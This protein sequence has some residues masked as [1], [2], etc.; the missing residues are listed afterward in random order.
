MP[1][2]PS[3]WWHKTRH[4]ERRPFLL[5]RTRLKEAVRAFFLAQD[6]MEVDTCPLQISPGNEV[7]LHPFQTELVDA[8]GSRYP[9]YLPTSPEFACKKLLAAGESKIFTFAF[10]FRNREKSPLHTP[11]FTMLEW[12]RAHEPY[13]TLMEDC[14]ALLKCAALTIQ[15]DTITFRGTSC[16]LTDSPERLTVAEAF[17]RYTGIDLLSTVPSGVPDKEVLLREMTRTHTHVGLQSTDTYSWSDLFSTVMTS[18]IEPHLGVTRPTILMEYPCC[19]AALA[20]IK[21]SNPQVAERF[22]LYVCGVELANGFGELTDSREQRRRFTQAMDLKEQLYGESVP[23][24][25]EFLQSLDHMP[26]SSGIALGF[27]RLA[28]LASEAP[29][30]DDVI[31]TPLFFHQDP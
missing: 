28:L 16:T 21:P 9:Y 13:T 29:R 5:Q 4:E 3:P 17:L 2:S 8:H 26:P 18:A 14:A 22:E 6:F 30:L 19:E 15:K 11:V 1:I 24:D 12:Y 23:L 31:W 25:E 7:H 10:S 27:D 20:R